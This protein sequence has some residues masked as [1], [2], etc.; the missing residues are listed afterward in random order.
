MR[1]TFWQPD[2][3][4]GIE[5]IGYVFAWLLYRLGHVVNVV[6]TQ[7]VSTQKRVS[8][9]TDADEDT[10]LVLNEPHAAVFDRIGAIKYKK[11]YSIVHSNPNETPLYA[12]CLSLNYPLH[13]NH[14]N[15]A[16]ILFPVSYPFAYKP[17]IKFLPDSERIYNMG[18]IGRF[19]DSKFDSALKKIMIEKGFKL[20]Y[21]VTDNPDEALPY[22]EQV[23]RSDMSTGEIYDLL[24]KTKVLLHPSTQECINLVAGEALTC[25]CTVIT[26]TNIL[27]QYDQ[28]F[29]SIPV[30]DL[31]YIRN[32]IKYDSNPAKDTFR[33]NQ[34]IRFNNHKMMMEH[35]S[36]PR[37]LNI[38]AELFGIGDKSKMTFFT[39]NYGDCQETTSFK[40]AIEISGVSGEY[41]VVHI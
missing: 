28:F 39:H 13:S 10:V 14:N 38:L 34:Q 19:I 40:N 18:F 31:E 36:M 7:D 22:A 32:V 20:D 23:F 17:D 24:S 33:E 4:S 37:T 5:Q 35:F 1:I 6:V 8:T 16:N 27:H 12:R 9:I 26:N 11:C 29:E 15:K 3:G 2:C 30:C 41:D 21:I 25:G